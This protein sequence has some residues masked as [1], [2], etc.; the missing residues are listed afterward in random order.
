M[1][2]T[3]YSLLKTFRHH[4]KIKSLED[5]VVTAPVSIRVKPTNRCNHFCYYCSSPERATY[6]DGTL[7]TFNPKD[8]IPW[9]IMQK[10][11][12][13]LELIG[14]KGI[15]FSGGGEPLLYRHIIDT[16]KLVD[17]T[18]ID[19][20]MI[21]N[22]QL[23]NGERA[24]LLK[25]AKWVRISL[26]S[27]NAKLFSETRKV[28]EKMF[29][30]LCDNIRNFIEIKDESCEVGVNCVVHNKNMDYVYEIAE[31]VKDLGMSHIKYSPV[32]FRDEAERYHKDIQDKIISRVDDAVDDLSDNNFKVI[33]L[34]KLEV[35]EAI[36][37]NRNYTYCPILQVSSCVG[38]DCNIY[39]C[40]DKL[41]MKDYVLGS[42]KEKSFPDIWF[43]DET[44]KTFNEFDPSKDCKHSCVW[45]E[46]NHLLNEYLSLDENNVNFP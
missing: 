6:L 23:L 2:G 37:F 27:H 33:N 13:D 12:V 10:L 5:G 45:E 41:Y 22:G 20:A 32:I 29:D 28:P 26:D 39:Y 38:A 18:N 4:S 16:L 19:L 3:T 35:P 1:K 15:I 40:H 9:K 14:T 8:F 11:I 25:D 7:D 34:Y 21:T 44:K 31:F 42:L 17:Y 24:E 43:S 30:E 36:T 46:R